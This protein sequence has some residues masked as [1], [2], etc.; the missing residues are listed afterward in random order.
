MSFCSWRSTIHSLQPAH[1]L[2]NKLQSAVDGEDAPMVRTAG[3]WLLAPLAYG[4]WHLASCLIL[5]PD[6][7]PGELA[8]RLSPSGCSARYHPRPGKGHGQYA[9]DIHEGVT[10]CAVIGAEAARVPSLRFCLF[11]PFSCLCR[12]RAKPNSSSCC[13]GVAL[14]RPGLSKPEQPEQPPT[15]LSTSSTAC[16]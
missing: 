12:C 7:C 4:F 3:L 5:V 2:W 14:A 1:V 9:S 6:A 15:T 8:W 16:S 10:P 11:W 13:V